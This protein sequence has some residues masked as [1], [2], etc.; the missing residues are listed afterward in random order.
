MAPFSQDKNGV[1][2]F[3]F[4]ENSNE[5]KHSIESQYFPTA[6]LMVNESNMVDG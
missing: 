2:A 5:K 4:R 1:T 3:W 6:F